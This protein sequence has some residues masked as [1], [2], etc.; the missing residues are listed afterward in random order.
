VV[1][2]TVLVVPSL[3]NTTA[4]LAA[5]S[6]AV[7][8]LYLAYVTPVLLRRLRPDFQ[9]GPWNLGRW[10]APV[11]WIAIVW[12]AIIC[13]LFVLPTTSPITPTTFNYTIVAVAVVLGGA[14]V[15]WMV[16]ARHWFTG[17]RHNIENPAEA[18]PAEAA[19][20][21]D[22]AGVGPAGAASGTD[23]PADPAGSG[24]PDDP[25]AA[26]PNAAPRASAGD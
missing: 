17:P 10:S 23:R 9:V 13:V 5:T 16:S 6:V 14:W 1:C 24:A 26:D 25:G 4:Y 8:G 20:A 3:W 19:L 21:A 7:I 12:V 18:D 22:L 11:G 2:S 15:Y